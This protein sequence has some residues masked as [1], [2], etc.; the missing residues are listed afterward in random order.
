MH[1]FSKESFIM[2]PFTYLFYQTILS[3][4]YASVKNPFTYLPQQNTFQLTLKR[5]LKFSINFLCHFSNFLETELLILLKSCDL[6]YS[7]IF[8]ISQLFTTGFPFLHSSAGCRAWGN[9]GRGRKPTSYQSS[10]ALGGGEKRTTLHFPCSF[11][12]VS[13]FGKLWT[14]P[15]G[16]GWGGVD[17]GQS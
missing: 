13:S 5:T 12:W 14:Q 1:V 6:L 8:L 3:P 10:G 16:V 4:V 7:L 2:C 17:K 11:G 15:T 9:K